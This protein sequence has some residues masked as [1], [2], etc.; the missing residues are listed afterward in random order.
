MWND[1]YGKI[2]TGKYDESAPDIENINRISATKRTGKVLD[3]GIGDGSNSKYL[4]QKGY[5]VYGMDISKVAVNRMNQFTQE[6]HWIEADLTQKLP[7]DNNFFDVV[8]SRLSLHYFDDD[9][10]SDIL[11]DFKRVM[12]PNGI[13]FISVKV[14]N[15][16]NINTGKVM[17]TKEQW[18]DLLEDNFGVLE[19]NEVVKQPYSYD[20]APSNM[21]EIYAK[22]N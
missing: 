15:V 6:G 9:T 18:Y 3:V 16:G 12:K 7:F 2:G 20:P 1:L 22:P 19:M 4:L 10:T 14:A 11:D 21:L 17:R 13:L 8:F 5:D